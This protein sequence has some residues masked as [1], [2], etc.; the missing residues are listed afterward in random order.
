[1]SKTLR[2]LI[3]NHKPN[4]GDLWGCLA[5]R[6]SKLIVGQRE[7]LILKVDVS[8]VGQVRPSARTVSIDQQLRSM[9]DNQG[10]AGCAWITAL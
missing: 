1:M 6:T 5:I 7:E 9:R 10:E 4:D 3:K 2:L 8:N